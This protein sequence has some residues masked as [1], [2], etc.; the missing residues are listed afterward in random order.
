MK[1]SKLKNSFSNSETPKVN[2]VLTILDA[3]KFKTAFT[4]AKEFNKAVKSG[5]ELKYAPVLVE[6]EEEADKI[7]KPCTTEVPTTTTESKTE[8]TENSEK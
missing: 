8:T 3:A 1:N 5:E 4:D 2:L 6:D 7:K